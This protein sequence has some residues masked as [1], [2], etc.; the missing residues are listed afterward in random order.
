MEAKDF[1]NY[2][3]S[4]YK[5][6]N[7]EFVIDNILSQKYPLKWFA[8]EKEELLNDNLPIIP[9]ISSKSD[10]L[11]KEIELYQ[12]EKKL[13]YA[14]FFILGKSENALIKDKR[15]CA[16]LILYSANIKTINE[17]RFLE[18]DRSSLT[19]NNQ[20]LRY[21]EETQQSKGKD[22]FL[23]ELSE[24]LSAEYPNLI[25][26]K[27]LFESYFS[28]IDATELL[29][30][31]ELWSENKLKKSFSTHTFDDG[32]CKIVPAACTILAKKTESSL[33]VLND[34]T[35]MAEKNEFNSSVAQLL[36]SEVKRSN[37]TA[38][39]YQSRLNSDQYKALQNASHY[40]N[41]VIVGPPGTGK[42]YTITS[43][44]SD[45]LINGQSVLVVSKTKQ[46]VEVLR[47][48]L[49][50]DFM[51]KDYLIHTTGHGYKNSLKA[52]V[53]RL[54]NGITTVRQTANSEEKIK[55]LYARLDKIEQTFEKKVQR[56]LL[57]SDLEFASKLSLIKKI[58]KSYINSPLFSNNSLWP[59][60]TELNEL[61]VELDKKIKA[62]AKNKIR[63][64]I[65]ESSKKYRQNVALFYDALDTSSF[66]SYKKI[67]ERINYAQTLKVFP[68]WL[69]NLSELN[70][71]LP[72]QQD[73]F[74]LVIIDEATQCD[75]ATALP[76]I[77]RAKR[78]VVAGD[79]NQL[80]HYSF[81]SQAH[82]RKLQKEFNLPEDKIFDYRNRSILDFYVYKL[83]KQ[84]QITF[85]REHFRSSPSL[86]EFSNKQFYDGQLEV[87]KS[88]PT[89][90]QHNQIE[91][92]EV[93]GTRYKSGVNKE[94]AEA[95]IK[96]LDSLI[97]EYRNEENPPSIGIISL[98]SSQV[99]YINKLLRNKYELTDL[100]RF[101][102]I[103]GTPYNFQGSERE[104]I[105]MSFCVCDA[106]HHSAFIHANKPEVLNVAITRAKSFQYVFK[107]ISNASLK[108]ESL[109]YQY[110]NFIPNFTHHEKDEVE[111]DDFQAQV[112]EALE[113]QGYDDVR[114]AYPLAGCSL[115]ILV[116]EKGQH[117]FID[118][119]GYPGEFKEAFTVERY[120]TLARTG[121]KSFPL[122]YSYWLKNKDHAINE[123]VHQMKN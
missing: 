86:I 73:M 57:K 10:E 80:R 53:S 109:L 76:A 118:L 79:P 25:G 2:Y 15:I 94:E 1:Y 31:P 115:D 18:I 44:I 61:V 12:L 67:L 52:K 33:H 42:T 82:Q 70:A 105:L 113:K 62:Y 100:K 60:I 106:T 6:D 14:C 19:I 30:F 96:K 9:Y 110:F 39:Y 17:E 122:H 27:D 8:S 117:F 37:K 40:T 7:K 41:S 36:G 3:K 66:T 49:Y 69:V 63:N 92:I 47:T 23:S 111:K 116:S 59:L 55:D 83:N 77:Y 22:S 74:D 51:L 112:V 16:P 65:A 46:A 97:K 13:F 90:T 56:E 75:I 21:L 88:T 85:L 34:L 4:C 78:V 123:L 95:I 121:I 120:K 35:A 58:K 20:I 26:L 87:L 54:L 48:M 102:L 32:S 29:M 91:L 89:H 43:I 99:N 5:A 11:E 72:L 24:L 84:E 108:K 71:V 101:K 28:N 93:D 68:L 107:S 98:F 38:S 119:I 45:A 104:I 64:N 81:V 50:E 114:C 103:C